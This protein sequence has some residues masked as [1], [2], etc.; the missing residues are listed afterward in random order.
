MTTL[1]QRIERAIA[2]DE[3]AEKTR[4]WQVFGFEYPPNDET[5]FP[6]SQEG[7][8]ITTYM[9]EQSRWQ[10]ARLQPILAALIECVEALDMCDTY[11]RNLD[12]TTAKHFSTE[13]TCDEALANLEKVIG[14]EG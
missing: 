6:K 14:G 7:K 11:F 9:I 3:A 2:F 1:K 8:M 4:A 13:A 12:V 10:S 5:Q